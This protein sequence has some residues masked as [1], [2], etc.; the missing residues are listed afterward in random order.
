MLMQS[1]VAIL[2]SIVTIVAAVLA[3][4]SVWGALLAWAGMLMTAAFMFGIGRSLGPVT[5]DRMVGEK[6][7]AKV[8]RMVERW[9]A[10][11][12]VFARLTPIVS[13]DAISFVAGVVC[14]KFW[15]FMLATAVGTLPLVTLIAVLGRDMSRL[16]TGLVVLSVAAVLF[17]GGY[18]VYH[19]LQKRHG[20]KSHRV[21]KTAAA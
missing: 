20:G 8:E 3:Y 17:F 21:S 1:I 12:I 6:T 4:G 16:K 2:P 9:G 19:W 18:L 5:V 14:M 13:T 10:W 7:R 15:R 11:A